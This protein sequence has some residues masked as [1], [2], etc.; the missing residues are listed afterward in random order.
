METILIL[1]IINEI[2]AGIKLADL[3][4]LLLNTFE[5]MKQKD[6]FKNQEIFLGKSF[7]DI[8]LKDADEI[9]RAIEIHDEK[10]QEEDLWPTGS[11]IYEL[12][13]GDHQRI[14]MMKKTGFYKRDLKIQQ[15]YNFK[16]TI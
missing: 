8:C 13:G 10:D 3:R 12:C 1:S 15:D 9:G 2:T 11:H 4:Y 5:T 14:E 7:C 16:G 6:F